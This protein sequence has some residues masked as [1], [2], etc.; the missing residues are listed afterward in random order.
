MDCE[1][2]ATIFA[3]IS[4]TKSALATT[5]KKIPRFYRPSNSIEYNIS[6]G[7]REFIEDTKSV[8]QNYYILTKIIF[9][10]I[11]MNCCDIENWWVYYVYLENANISFEFTLILIFGHN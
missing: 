9:R 7:C 5:E 11:Q 2:C 6:L 10:K 8:L 4:P 1:H 3:S